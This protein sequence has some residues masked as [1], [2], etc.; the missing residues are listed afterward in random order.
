M[1]TKKALDQEQLQQKFMHF[2]F[3]QE[4]MGQ[5]TQQVQQLHQ[6]NQNLENAKQTIDE[7][8][9]T[10][11]GTEILAPIADGLFIKVNLQDKDNLLIN[12]GA[13][14]AVEKK[15]DVVKAQLVTQKKDLALRI[16]EGEAI[17]QQLQR[18]AMTIYQEIE[19]YVQ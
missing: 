13:E 9:K 12:V 6:Q 2:K 5:I 3:L 8:E 17:L 18:E 7:L 10:S 14:V 16:I 4:Q 19:P 11:L 1:S 15:M